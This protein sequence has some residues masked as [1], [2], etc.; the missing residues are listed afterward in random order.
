MHRCQALYCLTIVFC[1]Q[2]VRALAVT[3]EVL[4]GV[5]RPKCR[6][7]SQS[8]GFA[9]AYVAQTDLPSVHLQHIQNLVRNPTCRFAQIQS[10]LLNVDRTVQVARAAEYSKK[11]DVSVANQEWM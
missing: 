2:G 1:A 11:S 5:F 7:L 10:S 3:G 8:A 4:R 9:E 6:P